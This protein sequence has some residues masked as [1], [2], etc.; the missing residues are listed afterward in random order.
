MGATSKERSIAVL[1]VGLKFD[2]LLKKSLE[3]YKTR[4]KLHYTPEKGEM[5]LI[6]QI[7]YRIGVWDKQKNNTL[8]CYV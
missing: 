2:K 7:S 3:C 1:C 5:F 4:N 8:L 6:P